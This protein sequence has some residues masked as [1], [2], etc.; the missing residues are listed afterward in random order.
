[1]QWWHIWISAGA[2]YPPIYPDSITDLGLVIDLLHQ[3]TNGN[4]G[5]AP[6]SSYK[7]LRV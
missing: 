7:V 2:S 4:R 6:G 3:E 5:V 1:M